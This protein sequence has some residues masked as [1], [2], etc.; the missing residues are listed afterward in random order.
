LYADPDNPQSLN[1]YQYTYNN[2]LKYTDPT[3]H[4]VGILAPI[5]T[6]VGQRIIERATPYVAAAVAA[7]GTA[8]A[9]RNSR[10]GNT[11]ADD[12]RSCRDLNRFGPYGTETRQ[13]GTIRTQDN[14]AG[15]ATPKEVVIDGS[16]HP[17]AAANAADAQ[18]AGQP[19]VVTVDRP[20][21]ADRRRESLQGTK[22]VPGKD[23][24]EYPPAVFKEGGRGSQVRPINPSD[25]RGAG[26]SVGQQIKDVSNGDKVKITIINWLISA[27]Y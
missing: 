17:E 11:I 23:R 8:V 1:K 20:G 26:A 4:C 21:A 27:I 24:D 16:K 5:C 18:K 12:C 14:S 25:N 6:P 2:P 9:A 15:N 22:P 3:G 7:L 19:S 13:N 10:P